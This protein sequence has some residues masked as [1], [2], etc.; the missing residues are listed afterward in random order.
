M[1][2][3]AELLKQSAVVSKI[4]ETPRAQ[5]PVT[6]LVQI[7]TFDRMVTVKAAGRYLRILDKKA[8]SLDTERDAVKDALRRVGQAALDGAYQQGTY[9]ASADVGGVKV[10]RANKFSPVAYNRDALVEAVGPVEYSLMF[11]E[12]AALEF[13]AIDNLRQFIHACELAGV[14]SMGEVKE[15]VTAKTELLKRV[16]EARGAMKADVVELLSKCAVDQAARVGGK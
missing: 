8:K 3:A 5:V 6:E 16:C 15:V 2:K 1:S 10:S 9:Y 4:K 14:P 7:A 12:A 11:K 13:K